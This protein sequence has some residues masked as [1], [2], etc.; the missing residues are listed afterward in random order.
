MDE[1]EDLSY[2]LEEWME[3]IEPLVS[4]FNAQNF[5]TLSEENLKQE[6]NKCL[7]LQE[8]VQAQ[9]ISI[10]KLQKNMLRPCTV[11]ILLKATKGKSQNRISLKQQRFL[12]ND[13]VK[14]S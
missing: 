12:K 13:K 1:I 10:G 6:Q 11:V 9:T 5:A 3:Q 4:H 8:G 2:P 14:V 7:E